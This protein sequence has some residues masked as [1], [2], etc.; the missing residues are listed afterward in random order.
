M[1]NPVIPRLVGK[2][3]VELTGVEGNAFIE[4]RLA[5][6]KTRN[7]G[8]IDFKWPNSVT[9]QVEKRSTYFELLNDPIL[10][11]GILKK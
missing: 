8:W 2:E 5:L 9:N 4:Q 11:H 1:A 6:L 7:S 10:S 3:I